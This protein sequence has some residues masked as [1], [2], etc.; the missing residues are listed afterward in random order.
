MR[1]EAEGKTLVYTADTAYFEELSEFAKGADVL[2]CESNFYKGMDGA[3][4]G[5][6]TSEEA[7][8]LQQANVGKLI[9]TH[10]PHFGN[11]ASIRMPKRENNIAG[12]IIISIA[13]IKPGTLGTG[14][15]GTGPNGPVIRKKRGEKDV[16]Y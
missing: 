7:G 11:I 6:M 13:G 1:I 9:L 15:L 12:E 4:A 16:I 3:A 8:I 5:H 2:L 10:L 14:N